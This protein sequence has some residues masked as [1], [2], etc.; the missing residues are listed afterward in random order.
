MMGCFSKAQKM[1]CA[2]NDRIEVSQ[3][4][5]SMFTIIVFS[6]QSYIKNSHKNKHLIYLRKQLFEQNNCLIY[7]IKIYGKAKG[8]F[9]V[10]LQLYG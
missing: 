9:L 4:L 6:F 10:S 5:F 8:N 1:I 7:Q 3:G 2:Q